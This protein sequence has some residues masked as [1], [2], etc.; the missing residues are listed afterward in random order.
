MSD[1][2][3]GPRPGQDVQAKTVNYAQGKVYIFREDGS[4][5]AW[6]VSPIAVRLEQNR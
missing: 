6:I 2:G 4:L 3:P 5:S 1:D